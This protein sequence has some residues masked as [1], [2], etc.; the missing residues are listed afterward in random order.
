V[1]LTPYQ[2]AWDR[3]R[4]PECCDQE[5]SMLRTAAKAWLIGVIVRRV[6]PVVLLIALLV[7]LIW[8]R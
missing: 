6:L 2:L 5:V 7:Y 1:A 8:F 3:L 4:S